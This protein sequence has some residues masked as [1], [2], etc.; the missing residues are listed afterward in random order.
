MYVLLRLA[1]VGLVHIHDLN[2]LLGTYSK[3]NLANLGINFL[4]RF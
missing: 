3:G 1:T 4:P 2:G